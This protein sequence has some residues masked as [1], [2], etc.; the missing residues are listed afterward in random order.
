MKLIFKFIKSLL[1]ILILSSL[2][3]FIVTWASLSAE[4]RYFLVQKLDEVLPFSIIELS[5]TLRA[6]LPV[7]IQNLLKDGFAE[8]DK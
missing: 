4:K 7:E 2:I 6:A 5:N 8:F 3:V 1:T